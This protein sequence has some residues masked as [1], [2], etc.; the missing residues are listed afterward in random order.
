ML[1]SGAENKATIP[2]VQPLPAFRKVKMEADKLGK[3]LAG[4]PELSRISGDVRIFEGEVGVVTSR[5]HAATDGVSFTG[6]PVLWSPEL[7]TELLVATGRTK[8]LSFVVA[9]HPLPNE[10]YKLASYF[11]MLGDVMPVALAYNPL[12][13][14]ELFWTSC[15][16]CAGE[17]GSVSVREDHHVVIVQH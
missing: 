5:S 9:L 10:K 1:P 14:K 6:S 2:A 13:R 3:I 7:G 4:F 17:Q 12:H 8:N 16:G 11:L 15:W